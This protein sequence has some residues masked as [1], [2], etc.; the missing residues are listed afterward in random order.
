MLIKIFR[1]FFCFLFIIHAAPALAIDLEQAPE[2]RN[3]LQEI[4]QR[5]HLDL[6]QL[7]AWFSQVQFNEK[8]IEK[9]KQP[10]PPTVPQPWQLRKMKVLSPE[11]VSRG[12]TFWKKNATVLAKAEKKYGIPAKVI[13]SIFGIETNYGQHMGN[14]TAINSLATFAFFSSYKR[15]YFKNELTQFLLLTREQ[16]WNPFSI[17]SSFDGGLG[18]PQFMPS[19]YREYA[20]DADGDKH[21][22]LFTDRKDAIASIGNYL[23]KKGNWKK[24]VPIAVSAKIINHH[25]YKELLKEKGKPH[26][27]LAQLKDYGIVPSKKVPPHLPVGVVFFSTQHGVV[28]WITFPNYNAIRAYNGSPAYA[29]AVVE[30]GNKMT[31]LHK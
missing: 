15:A 22:N 8:I 6:N 14:Y 21:S 18:L 31:L 23:N 1:N 26:F 27:T 25:K 28:P 7:E 13:V 16:G 30:L 2:V 29:V 9:F 11:L 24:G 5:Y 4:S 20:I 19:S 10:P 12:V 17:R 3:Y